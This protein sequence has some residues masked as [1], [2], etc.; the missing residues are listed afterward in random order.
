MILNKNIECYEDRGGGV[1]K[2]IVKL[3]ILNKSSEGY[4]DRGQGGAKSI[5]KQK[6]HIT[7]ANVT[8]IVRVVA[9]KLL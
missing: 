3:K 7:C 8:W 1:P 5:V 6:N 2:T 4:K 9:P